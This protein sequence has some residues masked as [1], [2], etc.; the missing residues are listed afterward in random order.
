MADVIFGL[1]FSKDR[2]EAMLVGID[3]EATLTAKKAMCLS[4]LTSSIATNG[5]TT[6][7][8]LEATP[9]ALVSGI[10][11]LPFNRWYLPLSMVGPLIS[12][13]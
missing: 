8:D 5:M 7:E 3:H 4:L 6:L 9:L 10:P 2:L 11:K 13:K 12:A 1:S